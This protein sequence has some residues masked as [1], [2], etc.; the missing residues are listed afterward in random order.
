MPRIDLNADVA[1]RTGAGGLAD[2]IAILGAV[3]SANVACGFHA[4]DAGTMRAICEAAIARDVRIGA[5][6]GYDDRAG[7]G[8]RE[9]DVAPRRLRDETL[10][11]LGALAACAAAAGGRLAYVKPHGALYARCVADR[12]AADAIAAA[13]AA[14]ELELA[15]LGPPGSELLAAATAAGL[16]A[17]AEGFADRAYMPDGTLVPRGRAG[18]VLDASQALAQAERIVGTGEAI[19]TDGS[20]IAVVVGSLCVHSDTPGAAALADRLRRSLERAGVD[21]RPFA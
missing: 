3:T 1:E 11:Q 18:S 5:H 20:A 14:I 19:A 13:A 2:D 8:R 9:L 7:F 4:G 6:V 21:V 17:T 15:L 12:P 16:A 10:Y